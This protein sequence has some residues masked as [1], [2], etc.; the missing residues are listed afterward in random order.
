MLIDELARG[1]SVPARQR[2]VNAIIDLGYQDAG[3][4]ASGS[5]SQQFTT[6]DSE[7]YDS[8]VLS[9]SPRQRNET[10]GGN[11]VDDSIR[12]SFALRAPEWTEERNER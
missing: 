11:N 9:T 6:I 3:S 12:A 2:D 4:F 1:Q 5:N 7:V 10:R 8:I